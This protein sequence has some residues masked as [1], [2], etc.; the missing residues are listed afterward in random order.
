MTNLTL[1]YEI[2]TSTKYLYFSLQ[3]GIFKVGFTQPIK[4]LLTIIFF[5]FKKTP[6]IYVKYTLWIITG[7]KENLSVFSKLNKN[8]FFIDLR[9]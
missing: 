3:N 1:N 8:F 4:I 5:D 6:C 7:H 9:A 2:H